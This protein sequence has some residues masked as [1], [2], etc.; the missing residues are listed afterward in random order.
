MPDNLQDVRQYVDLVRESCF[1]L[2]IEPI[3]DTILV[4]DNGHDNTLRLQRYLADGNYGANLWRVRRY[5]P[6]GRIFKENIYYD[7]EASK[8]KRRAI[9]LEL[10]HERARRKY[11]TPPTDQ[12][13]GIMHDVNLITVANY[14]KQEL[15]TRE[16]C[17]ALDRMVAKKKSEKAEA[18]KEEKEEKKRPLHAAQAI[19]RVAE[20]W[21]KGGATFDSIYED[22]RLKMERY[23]G[24]I[25]RRI[26]SRL[27]IN[28]HHQQFLKSKLELVASMETALKKQ[29]RKKK[30]DNRTWK[31]YFLLLEDDS[32][33]RHTTTRTVSTVSAVS[34]QAVAETLFSSLSTEQEES[35]NNT[36]ISSCA[37]TGARNPS[38]LRTPA[39]T[40]VSIQNTQENP[41][42][43]P[44]Q[45]LAVEDPSASNS[46]VV[47]DIIG[48]ADK[49]QAAERASAFA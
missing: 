41:A 8:H 25:R 22:K 2:N 37:S 34:T 40:P 31:P 48:A 1:A 27:E 24:Q 47:F 32:D 29:S 30:P 42:F 14:S 38:P 9:A 6:K 45:V 7:D 21:F 49:T 19:I 23:A 33:I 10:T 18:E 12:A 28:N 16:W 46:P 4:R 39:S 11:I 5:N 13:L 3:P 35:P 44:Q 17:K 36:D 20:E 15:R 26:Q 43:A